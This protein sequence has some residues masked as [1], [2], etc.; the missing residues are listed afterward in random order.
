MVRMV[1]MARDIQLDEII[2][3]ALTNPLVE[4]RHT[5][6][7]PP[8][9]LSIDEMRRA[10][11]SLQNLIDVEDVQISQAVARSGG[12]ARATMKLKKEIKK[13]E[14][15]VVPK[16]RKKHAETVSARYKLE[17]EIDQLSPIAKILHAHIK[18]HAPDSQC[19]D[20]REVK[21]LKLH[22]AEG[23]GKPAMEAWR[24][25]QVEGRNELNAKIRG[26]HVPATNTSFYGSSNKESD[27]IPHGMGVERFF[28]PDDEEPAVHNP[29]RFDDEHLEKMGVKKCVSVWI[30]RATNVYA[31]RA[32]LSTVSYVAC[33]PRGP[34]HR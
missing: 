3:K 17:R 23:L 11:A 7:V 14:N 18:A 24:K 9:S 31:S 16:L 25:S 6:Y 8:Q 32:L 34:L 15:E 29:P 33:A 1:Q 13:L 21:I 22:I 27:A 5:G 28:I 26:P 10:A 19:D 12:A 4:V 20:S 30:V 2:L